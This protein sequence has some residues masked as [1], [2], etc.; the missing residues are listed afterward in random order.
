MNRILLAVAA[1]GL[2]A[3]SAHAQSACSKPSKD[4]SREMANGY[5]ACMLAGMIVEGREPAVKLKV[6]REC[7]KKQSD[8]LMASGCSDQEADKLVR[9]AVRDRASNTAAL[10]PPTP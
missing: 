6:E 9:K 10:L 2:I 4:Q 8:P 7:L 1:A 5:I 3:G